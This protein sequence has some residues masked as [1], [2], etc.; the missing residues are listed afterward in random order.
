MV[1]EQ[2]LRIIQQRRSVR[3]LDPDRQIS[4][5]TLGDLIRTIENSPSA[6][7]K[8]LFHFTIV[9]DKGLLDDMAEAIRQVMLDGTQDQIEKASRPGYSPLHHAPTII[10]I[11]GDIKSG[12][13][14]QTDC[15]IAAG[16]IIAAAENIG[17]STCFT[18]SSVFMF[19]GEEGEA[20]KKRL[21]IPEGYQAVGAVALGYNANETK[22]AVPEHKVGTV[23]ILR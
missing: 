5:E 19:R 14:V 1:C 2:G 9:Q 7:N 13:N 3:T 18:G 17:L 21:E 10:M 12:F 11:S 23:T 4:D 15:G 6:H 8:Q 16:L 22:P 20:L